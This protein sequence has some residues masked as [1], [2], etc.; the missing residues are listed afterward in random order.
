MLPEVLAQVDSL[1]AG[2]PVV[3]PVIARL[4]LE[5]LR[6]PEPMNSLRAR[7]VRR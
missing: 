1:R 3:N 4:Q 5:M 2:L 7:E 6:S